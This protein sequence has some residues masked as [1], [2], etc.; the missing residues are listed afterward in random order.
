MKNTTS[1]EDS[2]FKKKGFF[3]ALYSC[4]GAVAVLALVMTLTNFGQ[5]GFQAEDYEEE[6][7]YVGA[8]QVPPYMAQVDEEAWFRPRQTSPPATPQPTSPPTRS[9]PTPQV[10]MHPGLPDPEP[11]QP[12]PEPPPVPPTAEVVAPPPAPV[13]NFTPFEEGSRL[14]WPV[15]GDIAMRFSMDA[16]IYDPTLVQFRTNDDLRISAESGTQVQAGAGGRVMAIGRNVVRGNYVKI[17]HGN[18]WIATYGQLA[19]TKLVRE[20]DVVQ[21]GQLLGT[22]GAP[23]LFGS[24]HGY[25][26]NLRVT[27]DDVAVDPYALLASRGN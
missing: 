8:D 10:P 20:G 26:V 25:H 16:L 14:L 18:G 6:A 13:V 21:A 15:Y 23:S 11:T 19:D 1:G 12:S 2:I 5:P 3:I 9:T 22:V 17:D 4:L 7:A 27:R 24:M